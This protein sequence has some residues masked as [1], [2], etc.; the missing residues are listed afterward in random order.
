MENYKNIA[1]ASVDTRQ[2]AAY[3][4]KQGGAVT[5]TAR[6]LVSKLQSTI[7]AISTNCC[8]LRSRFLLHQRTHHEVLGCHSDSKLSVTFVA[9]R[10]EAI[11]ESPKR[12]QTGAWLHG[13]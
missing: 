9:E 3:L 1:A 10:Q 6:R 12:R 4:S 13:A 7:S 11:K 2:S 5:R 8:A